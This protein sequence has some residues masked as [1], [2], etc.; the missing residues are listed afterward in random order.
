M[1]LLAGV[2]IREP[3]R[4]G[5]VAAELPGIGRMIV[6]GDALAGEVNHG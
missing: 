1:A 3:L 4:I 2:V 5:A 6:T